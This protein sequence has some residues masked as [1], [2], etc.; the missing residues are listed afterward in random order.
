MLYQY[1]KFT[2][3]APAHCVG[4][5][6]G[7]YVILRN[8]ASRKS[9]GSNVSTSTSYIPTHSTAPCE[10]QHSGAA[11]RAWQPLRCHSGACSPAPCQAPRAVQSRATVR[12]TKVT[13]HKGYPPRASHCS[14]PATAAGTFRTVKNRD[15]SCVKFPLQEGGV[16]TSRA[17][18]RFVEIRTALW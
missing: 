2:F 11:V 15:R 3:C 6:V 10:E 5:M 17:D 7:C 12:A 13:P 16:C 18:G 8:S 14:V 1:Q 9:S 4:I